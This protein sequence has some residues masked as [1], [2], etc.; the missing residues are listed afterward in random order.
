M[1][2]STNNIYQRVN[3]HVKKLKPAFSGTGKLCFCFSVSHTV[4]NTNDLV[5]SLTKHKKF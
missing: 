3:A 4:L 2:F 5:L 1:V